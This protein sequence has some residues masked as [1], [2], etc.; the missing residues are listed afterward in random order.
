MADNAHAKR[1]NPIS[2]AKMTEGGSKNV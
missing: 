1:G 2:F